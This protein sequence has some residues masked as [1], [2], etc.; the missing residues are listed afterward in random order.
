[1]GISITDKRLLKMNA[2]INGQ[3]VASDQ[4]TTLDV[5]NPATGEVIAR[6][7]NCGTAETRRAI[8]AAQVA[9]RGWAQTSIK[10]RSAILRRWF[11]L[12]MENQED[13]AQILTAEQGKP[14]AEARGEIAMIKVSSMTASSE[15][16]TTTTTLPT[17]TTDTIPPL[18]LLLLLH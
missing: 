17:T 12:M 16:T 8:E 11:N 5:T 4:G 10:E 3:W 14:L 15:S 9:Q 13:L 7:A 18:L 1:M 2:Y 6:V